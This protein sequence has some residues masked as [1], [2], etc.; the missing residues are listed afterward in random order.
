MSYQ[1][2]M[3]LSDLKNLIFENSDK[4]QEILFSYARVIRKKYFDTTVYPRGV[5]EIS[6]HCALNCC[7]CGMR[8]NNSHLSRYRLTKNQIFNAARLMELSGVKS[9]MLQS[10]DDY[11]FPISEIVEIVR[12]LKSETQLHIILCL[13]ER[14]RN[15]MVKLLNAG[16]N[17]YILKLE[18]INK[19]LFESLRPGKTFDQRL[20]L[21]LFL[22]EIGFEISSGFI[23][24]LP[25][26]SLD[27]L[28][29]GILLLKELD[30]HAA[31][32][33]PFIPNDYSPLTGFPHGD[34]NITLNMIA[35]LR[36]LLGNILIPS[37]SALSMIDSEGQVRG[38]NA[39][40]N[41]ITINFTPP[42]FSKEYV[43]YDSHRNIVTLLSAIETIKKAGLSSSLKEPIC[44]GLTTQP[45]DLINSQIYSAFKTS[46]A[47]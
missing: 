7:Y 9:I 33:S 10:G 1:P 17:M 27:E 14:K 31:S 2:D 29:E 12:L 16:A 3:N 26:Q 46:L 42:S 8:R 5:L 44:S 32:V 41:V 24:G 36:I 34:F 35:A 37:V 38:F 45:E 21:L 23:V 47:R 43:I 28:V 18:T 11:S 19:N 40:S 15:D 4:Q 30:V 39:G 22:K 20:N 25:G 13:G 6:N